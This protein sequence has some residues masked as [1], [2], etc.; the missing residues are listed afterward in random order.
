MGLCHRAG[1]GEQMKKLKFNVELER[2]GEIYKVESKELKQSK[3]DPEM[4]TV[5]STCNFCFDVYTSRII[6]ITKI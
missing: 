2:D 1:G 6:A 4:T 3:D 5:F